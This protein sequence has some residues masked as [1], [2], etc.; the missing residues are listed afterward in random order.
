MTHKVAIKHPVDLA[1]GRVLGMGDEVVDLDLT[2]PHNAALV[3]SGALIEIEEKS[4]PEPEP[5]EKSPEP[6][7]KQPEK[8]PAAKKST[9]T[10]QGESK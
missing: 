10:K 3:E 4:S 9:P 6:E 2:E 5:E 8:K 1:D 7:Q